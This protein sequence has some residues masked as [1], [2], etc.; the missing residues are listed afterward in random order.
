MSAPHLLSEGPATPPAGMSGW[1]QEAHMLSN[2]VASPVGSL[3][4]VSINDTATAGLTMQ[5]LIMEAK[6]KIAE[7]EQHIL[8]GQG[9]LLPE[10]WA[11]TIHHIIDKAEARVRG[12]QVS[13]LQGQ[14]QQSEGGSVH[15]RAWWRAN[16]ALSFMIAE[17]F[18]SEHDDNG[19]T[20]ES[21][22]VE[23]ELS[24]SDILAELRNDHARRERKFVLAELHN[25]LEEIQEDIQALLTVVW[26]QMM[27]CTTLEQRQTSDLAWYSILEEER[28]I[29]LDL[30]DEIHDLYDPLHGMEGVLAYEI[31]QERFDALPVQL[32]AVF[33]M[34]CREWELQGREIGDEEMTRIVME[35][36]KRTDSLRGIQELLDRKLNVVLEME[37]ILEESD[38]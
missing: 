19:S 20:K 26:G 12:E 34:R 36:Q 3:S 27:A 30:N 2:T 15:S 17:E 14:N 22:L 5:Q 28:G 13:H 24:V 1:D 7:V 16:V 9:H 8:A 31:L 32:H 4:T 38:L 37:K 21:E 10:G 29:L 35:N 25:K 11:R 6:A 33:N 23:E 18:H